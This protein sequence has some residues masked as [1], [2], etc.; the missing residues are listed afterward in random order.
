MNQIV[1]AA[2]VAA[3]LLTGCATMGD[4]P[5]TSVNEYHIDEVIP[6]PADGIAPVRFRAGPVE[7]VEV[8]VRNRPT[9]KDIAEDRRK[10]DTSRPKPVITA[11]NHGDA[12]AWVSLES[13]LEDAA[14]TPLMVCNRRKPQELFPGVKDDWNTCFM[15]GMPTHEWPRVTHFHAKLTIRVREPTPAPAATPANAAK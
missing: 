5:G 8:R 3:V 13:I 14:G 10:M 4:V 2:T 7:L 12:L 11:F 1:C 15:E 6:L 9:A